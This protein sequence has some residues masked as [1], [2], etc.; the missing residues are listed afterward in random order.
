MAE[1]NFKAGKDQARRNRWNAIFS[2]LAWPGQALCGRQPDTPRV[3]RSLELCFPAP[4]RFVDERAPSM[5]QFLLWHACAAP[6]MPPAS[7]PPGT[8]RPLAI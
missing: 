2:R 3:R 4:P 6:R 1:K 8:V 5:Y 7:D